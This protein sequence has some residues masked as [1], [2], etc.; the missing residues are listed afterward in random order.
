MKKYDRLIFVSNSDTS[1]GPMA[2]A[3]MKSKFLLEDL[4]VSSKGIVVLFPEPIN[5]KAEAVLVSRGL[6][7]KDHMSEPLLQEDMTERTLILAVTE[8]ARQKVL[9]EYKVKPD[10]PLYVLSEFVKAEREQKDPYGG[11]LADYGECF[12]ELEALISRLVIL[13]NEEEL[14]C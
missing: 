9:K 2:Y 5:P 1:V 11:S 12:E 7:M 14:L 4:Q 6:S 3:I 10:Q 8:A 13:L